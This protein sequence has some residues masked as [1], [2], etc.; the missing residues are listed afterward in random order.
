MAQKDLNP[1]LFK[2][3]FQFTYSNNKE[4]EIIDNLIETYVFQY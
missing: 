4:A 3:G 1:D 2:I